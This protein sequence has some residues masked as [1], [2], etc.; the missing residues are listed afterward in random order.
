MRHTGRAGLDVIAAITALGEALHYV[1]TRERV[2]GNGSAAVDVAWA[3]SDTERDPLFVFEVESRASAGLTNNAT[4]VYAPSIDELGKPLFFFHLVVSASPDN[5]RIRNVQRLFGQQNYR[6]YRYNDPAE[7]LKFVADVLVQHRRTTD[8]IAP[9]AVAQTLLDHSLGGV[10]LV[11]A[12]MVGIEQLNFR[13]HYLHDYAVLALYEPILVDVLAARLR[14][15]AATTPD[16]EAPSLETANVGLTSAGRS[17][18]S[19]SADAARRYDG[20]GGGPGDYVPG[21]LEAAIQVYS[22][23]VADESGPAALERWATGPGT[24]RV[25]DAAFGLARDYDDFVVISAPL[26]YAWAGWLLAGHPASRDWIL[27]D[28]AALLERERAHELRPEFR[29]SALLW[30]AHLVVVSNRG[31][32]FP[33]S[34]LDLDAL[35]DAIGAHAEEGGGVPATFLL[36]PPSALG[37]LFDSP[38][39]LPWVSAGD[40]VPL[41]GRAVLRELVARHLLSDPSNVPEGHSSDYIAR[42]NAPDGLVSAWAVAPATAPSEIRLDPVSWFGRQGGGRRV[43]DPLAVCLGALVSHEVYQLDTAEVVANLHAPTLI[44][45]DR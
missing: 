41:P 35:W 8:I 5:D 43:L 30:L 31:Q 12:A 10:D 1:V 4:K 17:P 25:I 33:E 13:A 15:L 27:S 32:G 40:L 16:S 2:V 14:T 24:F 44:P 37:S 26:Q 3:R 39:P 28:L 29:R 34:S 9:L 45:E 7:R 38:E 18:S 6:V 21:L 23:D 11:R 19:S 36:R 20:Y 22:G 42:S